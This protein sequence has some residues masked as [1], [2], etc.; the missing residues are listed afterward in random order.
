MYYDYAMAAPLMTES[1]DTADILVLGM[2]TG[3]YAKQCL[4]YF[5]GA[6]AEGVEIDEKITDLAHSYFELPEDINVTPTTD[7]PFSLPVTKS[8]TSSW[9]T[10]I[11]I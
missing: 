7:G 2:G 3:T 10:P 1:P 4:R 5:S 8:M 9:L 11:R 6:K